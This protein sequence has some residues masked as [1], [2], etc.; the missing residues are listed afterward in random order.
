MTVRNNIS[1]LAESLGTILPLRPDGGELVV[2]DAESTDGTKE[3]LDATARTF[4]ELTV[5]S[6]R[7]NRGIGRN[8]AVRSSTGAI[9]LTQV[10][11]DNRYAPGVLVALARRLAGRPGT[12][13]IFT[14]GAA[15]HDPS[16]TRF[17]A[18]HRDA[19]ERAGGYPD[20]QERED[21]PLLLSAFRAGFPVERC[22]VPKVA[23]DLKPRPA[24]YAP[25]VPPW[26]R[27]SHTM[28]AA[29]KFRVMGYRYPEYSRLL[30]LTR[31]TA[32]RFAAGLALGA[33]AYLQGAVHRDGR[34]VV[35]RNDPVPPAP[36]ASVTPPP[37]APE[38]R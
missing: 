19:F 27:G 35:E 30:W 31:R 32:P 7:C 34:E 1:T 36:T 20:T 10:D 38:T 9:V 16:S 11:G 5:I 2:V 33:A 4:P 26:R 29:R 28:W 22:L 8:L 21:P 18:W 23:D 24:G 12:G 13:L 6:R 37:G 25:S 3:L 17:Y 14:V 15:D